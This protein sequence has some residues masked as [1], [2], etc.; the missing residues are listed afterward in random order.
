MDIVQVVF[1]LVLHVA[2]HAL[3]LL[4]Y[5]QTPRI[6]MLLRAVEEEGGRK[7][8]KRST[9]VTMRKVKPKIRSLQNRKNC[10]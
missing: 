5:E 9:K 3:R 10:E 8:R 4:L 1:R 2:E 6:A 7:D